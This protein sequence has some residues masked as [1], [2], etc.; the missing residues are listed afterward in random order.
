MLR[1]CNAGATKSCI[2]WWFIEW[3]RIFE[4]ALHIDPVIFSSYNPWY[5]ATRGYVMMCT[6]RLTEHSLTGAW[7]CRSQEVILAD[8]SNGQQD[9]LLGTSSV[10]GSG[11]DSVLRS[12]LAD[13]SSPFSS[14][15]MPL[16]AALGARM[17]ASRSNRQMAQHVLGS[18]LVTFICI[19]GDQGR[20]YEMNFNKNRMCVGM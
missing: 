17:E 3:N 13:R 5:R 16:V 9:E 20:L 19:C 15:G 10:A 14:G 2:L 12:L 7:L 11:P 18:Q 6:R 4:S 1:K 8:S